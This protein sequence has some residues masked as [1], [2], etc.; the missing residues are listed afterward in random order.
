MNK[1]PLYGRR[2]T[3][4]YN[5]TGQDF[6]DT[7]VLYKKDIEEFF[8]SFTHSMPQ[9]PLNYASVY[10]SLDGTNQYGIPANLLLN[11]KSDNDIWKKQVEDAMKVTRLQ[12]V[13]VLDEEIG[14]KVKDKSP[15]LKIHIST[16]GVDNLDPSNLD[17]DLIDT[18]NIDEPAMYSSRKIIDACLDAGIK[19][20]F[21]VNRNCMLGRNTTL[22][23]FAGKMI[24]CCRGT[25]A[26]C[27]QAKKALP[28]L[29]LATTSM[30]KE[31]AKNSY[32]TY[33]KLSTRELDNENINMLL[34]YW[35]NNE[36]TRRMQEVEITDSSYP[37]FLEWCELRKTCSGQCFICRKCKDIY[38]R[39]QQA[40]Q[41]TAV[42]R[43]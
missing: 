16:H 7:V 33:L 20:K 8:F 40:N 28:W 21:I 27:I 26:P 18:V 32:A 13:S 9:F 19:I 30:Y 35:T 6:F 29:E 3:V 1:P 38:E 42:Q 22:S 37:I 39:I 5:L 17:A 4:G 34:R 15:D 25:H 10:K 11:M 23:Q 24:T 36:P 31:Q 12:A 41:K 43:S 2:L 14:R